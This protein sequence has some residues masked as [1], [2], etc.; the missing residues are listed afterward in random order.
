MATDLPEL[1]EPIPVSQHFSR[2]EI[3][4]PPLFEP[5]DIPRHIDKLLPN[6]LRHCSV[7]RRS[8]CPTRSQAFRIRQVMTTASCGRISGLAGSANDLARRPCVGAAL[9]C[10]LG[11]AW[12]RRQARPRRRGPV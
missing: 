12:R 3:G 9:S 2:P 6:G 10:R 11:R 8:T 1:L 4:R 7:L 5:A